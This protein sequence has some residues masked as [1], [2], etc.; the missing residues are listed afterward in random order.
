MTD[1]TQS[2]PQQQQPEP[3]PQRA[4]QPVGGTRTART[5]IVWPFIKGVA[6]TALAGGGFFVLVA[7]LTRPTLGATRSAKLQWQQRGQ[8]IKDTIAA[9]PQAAQSPTPAPDEARHDG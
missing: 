6:T 3:P 4:D 7:A 2:P 1:E 8:E 9:E 5:E